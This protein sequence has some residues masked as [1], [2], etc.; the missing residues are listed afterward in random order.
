MG[1]PKPHYRIPVE[2]YRPIFEHVVSS[3]DLCTLAR[4]S[5]PAQAESERLLYFYLEGHDIENVVAVCRRI[6]NLPRVGHYVR[7]VVLSG[8]GGS[9]DCHLLQSLYALV[10][11]ALSL[12]PNLIRL[13]MLQTM[14]SVFNVILSHFPISRF[15]SFRLRY[16]HIPYTEHITRF[17]PNQQDIRYLDA[18]ITPTDDP[19]LVVPST[20]LPHLSCLKNSSH[21]SL[22]YFLSKRSITH[23]STQSWL[24]DAGLVQDAG[25]RMRALHCTFAVTSIPELFPRLELLS[26]NIIVIQFEGAMYSVSVHDV[27]CRMTRPHCCIHA[28]VPAHEM[29]WAIMEP[30][31]SRLK[32][33]RLFAFVYTDDRKCD[34]SDVVT[35]LIDFQRACP[36]LQFVQLVSDAPKE[37]AKPT[38]TQP[39]DWEWD[40]VTWVG[41]PMSES[42]NIWEQSAMEVAMSGTFGSDCGLTPRWGHN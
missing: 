22:V 21:D 2:L 7:S 24:L 18:D 41:L 13:Q 32:H 11:R 28:Q 1:I 38:C 27:F 36:T 26:V 4:T 30:I 31:L 29:D 25:L 6:C 40:G 14:H 12:T 17:L 8:R 37:L 16:F 5:R 33:L 35:T 3:K 9:S 39:R 23:L 42:P 34:V 15:W 10:A 20:F 19:H